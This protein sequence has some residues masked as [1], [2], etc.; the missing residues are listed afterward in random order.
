M[1]NNIWLPDSI[2]AAVQNKP[3][4]EDNVGM[5]GSR[6]FIFDDKVLKIQKHSA[7]TDNEFRVIEWLN[8][9]LPVPE[10][11]EYEVKDG[12]A[13]CFMTR[14]CGK[15]ACDESYMM[16]PDTLV[17]IAAQAM[18]MLWSVD[19]SDCPC[20]ASLDIKLEA[21]KYNV[22]NSLVDIENTEPETFGRGGFAS[23]EE[24]L[25]WLC[26]NRPEEEPVFS[27]G[28]FCLPNIFADKNKV[29][30]FIDLGRTGIA[31]KWQDI[32]ICYRSLKHNFEGAYNGGKP[33]R[34]YSPEML[35]ERLQIAPE[36]EK[37]RYYILLDELF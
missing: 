2:R 18:E 6:I 23:P 22:E 1:I 13:Y 35:F 36:P 9:R 14:I 30:G 33:Y 7:E 4:T 31:D 19:I 15:M 29:T 16:E 17:E 28:D 27:H 11:I 20:D 25:L 37:L 21:A 10:I 26:A 5:S 8:G 34:G 12:M 24:L 32:A 3:C